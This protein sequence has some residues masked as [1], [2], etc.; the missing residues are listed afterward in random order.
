MRGELHEIACNRGIF[1]YTKPRLHACRLE[2]FTGSFMHEGY[3]DNMLYITIYFV[4][5]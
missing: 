1:L 3:I 2:H 4:H 5:A